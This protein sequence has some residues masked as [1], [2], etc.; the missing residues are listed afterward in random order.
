MSHSTNIVL[1]PSIILS[2]LQSSK[3][4]NYAKF[5]LGVPKSTT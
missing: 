4:M 3:I 1:A 5:D 2:I